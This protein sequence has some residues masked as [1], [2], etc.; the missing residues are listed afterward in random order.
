MKSKTRPGRWR[1]EQEGMFA[2]LRQSLGLRELL[3]FLSDKYHPHRVGTSAYTR[4]RRPSLDATGKKNWPPSTNAEQGPREPFG[5][6]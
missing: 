5:S 1:Y 6:D 2:P 3:L 4:A